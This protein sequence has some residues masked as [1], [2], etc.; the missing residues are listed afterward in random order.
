MIIDKK[1]LAIVEA[2]E[3]IKDLDDKP[4]LKEYFNNFVKIKNKD[5]EEIRKKISSLNSPKIRDVHIVKIIDIMP[6]DSESL[7]KIFLELS[8][9]EEETKSLI[10]IVK[11]N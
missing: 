7:N 8:L 6:K 2:L 11:G 5:A 3:Y 4:V 10:D 9:T 1:P